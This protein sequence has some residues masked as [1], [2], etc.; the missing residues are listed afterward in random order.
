MEFNRGMIVHMTQG[1]EDLCGYKD[2]SLAHQLSVLSKAYLRPLLQRGYK[3]EQKESKLLEMDRFETMR[4]LK[5]SPSQ[6]SFKWQQ[7][8]NELAE[9]GEIPRDMLEEEE[10]FVKKKE[11]IEKQTEM[12]T[13]DISNIRQLLHNPFEEYYANRN[14]VDEEEGEM[15]RVSDVNHLKMLHHRAQGMADGLDKPKRSIFGRRQQPKKS[16]QQGLI[17]ASLGS[18]GV[19]AVEAGRSASMSSTYC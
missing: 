10:F 16:T 11:D 19:H 9:R 18:L 17:M 15:R 5:Q 7:A 6:S 12:L 4:E 14:L 13:K 1:I 2:R 3:N 8:V